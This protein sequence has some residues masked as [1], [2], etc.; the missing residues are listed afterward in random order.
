MKHANIS[1]FVPHV[2]CKHRC[3]FCD[4]RTITG[5]THL[6][7][8][9]DVDEAVM[10]ALSS[11]KVDPKNTEIAFFG[12]SFTAINKDYM[13]EL[14]DAANKYVQSNTVS[15]I[16]I[17][18][19]PDAI[20]R[21]ILAFLK[22]KGVKAIELGAQ[23]MCDEVLMKNERGHTAEDVRKA[24]R[25]IK[26]YGFELGL[27]MMTG[28]YGSSDETDIKTAEEIVSL[29]PDT[30]RIYPTVILEGTALGER[31]KSG[32]YKTHSLSESVELCAVLLEKFREKSVKVIRLGLH[33]IEEEKYLSG[34]WHPAFRELVEAEIYYKITLGKL[35]GNP[36][37]KYKISVSP[38]SVSKTVGQ[39]KENLAKLYKQGYVCKVVP[40]KSIREYEVKI[41]AEEK[42]K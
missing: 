21:E 10:V 4:Q 37:G 1:L 14:L 40:E 32:E 2:G 24:S 41:K 36:K 25:L 34:P 12:G 13:T 39:N 6:P 22:E 33:N 5:E 35:K 19:R 28:L 38:S 8:G 29:A 3:S 20:D 26:E 15:G 23:S 31:Y 18:T 7:H 27:Q 9:A 16:R 42:I 11:G 30:V 17:S